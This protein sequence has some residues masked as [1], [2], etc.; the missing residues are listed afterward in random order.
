MIDDTEKAARKTM[1]RAV[2]L[3]AAKPRSCGELRKRLLEKPWT[4][5]EIVNDVIKKLEGYKYV[6]DQQF[7]EELALSKLRQ[8]PQGRRRL[9][10]W[11]SQKDL[12]SETIERAVDLAY[13]Q[14]P[15][16]KL[17]D[18]SIQKRVRSKGRPASYEEERKFYEYLMR[19]G[20]SYELIREKLNRIEDIIGDD[21]GGESGV[22]DH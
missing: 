9:K 21:L 16:S 14:F 17:I 12:D 3:L 2:R 13:Q 22:E 15:E 6:D 1:D 19:L 18:S 5:L 8:K 11:I 4:N 20:F 7:A 10:L